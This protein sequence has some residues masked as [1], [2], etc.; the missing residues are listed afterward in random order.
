MLSINKIKY[1]RSLEQKKNRVKEKKIVLDG[2]RLIHEA[3]MQ[4]IDIE[5]I[6]A[7]KDIDKNPSY[8]SFID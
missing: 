1:L 2:F 7:D 5:H 3:L 6:W 8:K 4:N